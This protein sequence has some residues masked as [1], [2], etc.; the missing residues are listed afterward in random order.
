MGDTIKQI[1]KVVKVEK[2][3]RRGVVNPT[4]RSMYLVIW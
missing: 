2:Y 1:E 4:D 3:I